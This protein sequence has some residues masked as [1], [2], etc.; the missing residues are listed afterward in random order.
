LFD[1]YRN[2]GEYPSKLK[3]ESIGAALANLKSNVSVSLAGHIDFLRLLN[4]I[5]NALKH[6]F[7]N[8][9][10][11]LRGAEEPTVPVLGLKYNDLNNKEEFYNVSFAAVV[12]DFNRFYLTAI[13]LLREWSARKT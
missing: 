5:S 10:I 11:T 2:T 7:I 8:S 1:C 12:N 3:I 9:D 4:G 6:S 13:E